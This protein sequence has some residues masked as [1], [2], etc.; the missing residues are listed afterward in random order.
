MHWACAVTCVSSCVPIVCPTAT[1]TVSFILRVLYL[2]ECH[3]FPDKNLRFLFSV[4]LQRVTVTVG[5]A[6]GVTECV[7]E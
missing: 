7:S 2:H 4:Y 5:E 3:E 6:D 1:V